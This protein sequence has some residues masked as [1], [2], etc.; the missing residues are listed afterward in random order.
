MPDESTDPEAGVQRQRQKVKEEA[1][2]QASWENWDDVELRTCLIRR[3][4]EPVTAK[5][6]VRDRQLQFAHDEIASILDRTYVDENDDEIV[7][8][9]PQDRRLRR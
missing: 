4:V 2:R 9:I 8:E 1:E 6:W 3:G 7:F 5:G